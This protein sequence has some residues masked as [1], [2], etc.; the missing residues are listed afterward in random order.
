[1][2]DNS[3]LIIA[4]VVSSSVLVLVELVKCFEKRI[5]G[6]KIITRSSCC[7]IEVEPLKSSTENTIQ[8]R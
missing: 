8:K 1:M 4:S 2:S 7:N 5:F 3:G 6:K